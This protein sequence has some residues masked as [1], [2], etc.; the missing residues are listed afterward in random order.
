MPVV[1][2]IKIDD[3]CYEICMLKWIVSVRENMQCW[4]G[5]G[6]RSVL[7]FGGMMTGRG[8]LRSLEKY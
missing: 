2:K 1:C 5:T 7:D 4:C 3:T 6:D 8:T